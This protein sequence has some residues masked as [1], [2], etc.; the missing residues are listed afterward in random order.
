M[1]RKIMD[2]LSYGFYFIII[3]LI[4]LVVYLLFFKQDT[5]K[6]NNNTNNS[7]N[8]TEQVVNENI[9]L[10]KDNVILDIGGSFDLKTTLI[11]SNGN[12]IIKYESLDQSIATVS[13]TGKITGVAT[14]STIIVVTVDETDIKAECKVDVSSSVIEIKELFVN[15]ER[16]KIKLGDTY[17][18]NVSIVPNNAVDKTLIFSSANEKIL[19]VSDDG[20]VTGLMIGN[21]R[22]IIQSKTNP[23]VKIEVEFFV[24]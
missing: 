1:N 20:L 8:N 4:F 19:S 13:E 5:P 7:D 3:C 23:D 22:I 11:P 21:S 14:G 17:Q 10:N 24:E 2:G 6:K 12:E 15:E 16:V 9:K 18:L